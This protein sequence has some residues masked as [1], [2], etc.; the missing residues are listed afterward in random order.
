MPPRVSGFFARKGGGGKGGKGIGN[1]GVGKSYAGTGAVAGMPV[2]ALPMPP[3]SRRGPQAVLAV[4]R[5]LFGGTLG[6][7]HIA[8]PVAPAA[9]QAPVQARA[10]RQEPETEQDEDESPR[11][12]EDAKRRKKAARVRSQSDHDVDRGRRKEAR[13]NDADGPTSP[14]TRRG[15]SHER[16]RSYEHDRSR[17]RDRRRRDDRGDAL[18]SKGFGSKA[19]LIV[20]KLSLKV[21]SNS[22]LA[23]YFSKI[24][25]ELQAVV[26]QK[27]PLL[28][29]S[30]L[31]DE[32]PP[33]LAPSAQHLQSW[34]DDERRR[35]QE[36]KRTDDARGGRA[37][38]NR[39]PLVPLDDA[40]CVF[41]ANTVSATG[42]ASFFQRKYGA[43]QEMC[44]ATSPL[45]SHAF[46]RHNAGGKDVHEIFAQPLFPSG[47][48][49]DGKREVRQRSSKAGGQGH[50]G[51]QAIF[52]S[53]GCG[54][55]GAGFQEFEKPPLGSRLALPPMS[56]SPHL[57]SPL[58]AG[59]AGGGA[60]CG[61]VG[62]GGI[63]GGSFGGGFA[64]GFGQRRSCD[65]RDRSGR[66]G[67][68]K[69]NFSAQSGHTQDLFGDDCGEE[70]QAGPILA[71]EDAPGLSSGPLRTGGHHH[72]MLS[73][74]S[75][76]R[77]LHPK[78]LGPHDFTSD[79]VF[80]NSAG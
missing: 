9:A 72:H 80:M 76:R 44:G 41:P 70:D 4:G 42:D 57:D 6:L 34:D 26:A 23:G 22:D 28:Q 17:G 59:H 46:P 39:S 13:G 1:K 31:L 14:G 16:N 63:S 30:H 50:Q 58:G 51:F 27:E 74:A 2:D 77:V 33:P 40:N 60:F 43:G 7:G 47:S 61:D 54:G 75:S 19:A 36:R 65:N 24:Q 62:N 21:P 53:G 11:P 79:L 8:D 71:I 3:L 49:R 32:E 15:R 52:S 37:N 38:P 73:H 12:R 66:S 10:E 56:L 67:V 45:A 20:G 69:L 68:D 35:C 25:K 5:G 78:A 48:P 64:A 18:S 29:A 55:G